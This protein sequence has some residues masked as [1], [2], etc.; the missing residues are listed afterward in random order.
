MSQRERECFTRFYLFLW[1]STPSSESYCN[2]WIVVIDV[3]VISTT[4][5]DRHIHET[6]PKTWWDD[7]ERIQM[8]GGRSILPNIRKA[9]NNTGRIEIH[10]QIH[11][12]RAD[13]S[14]D[15]LRANG[16]RPGVHQNQ[17][18]NEKSPRS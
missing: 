9:P 16:W 8:K 12:L 10:K 17:Q 6:Q 3:V 7:E 5:V 4:N 15:V 18:E 14:I 13:P 1:F 11:A 2:V